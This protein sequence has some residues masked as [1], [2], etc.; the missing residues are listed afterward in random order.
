MFWTNS[1]ASFFLSRSGLSANGMDNR[2]LVSMNVETLTRP[3]APFQI[4]LLLRSYI[5][6]RRSDSHSQVLAEKLQ[7][8]GH[9]LM[10][11]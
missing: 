1:F 11:L 7:A 10:C 6:M 2:N 9:P 8:Q 5:S 3:V 4:T